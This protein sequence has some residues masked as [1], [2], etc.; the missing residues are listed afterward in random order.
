MAVEEEL[1]GL[2]AGAGGSRRE[3]GGALGVRRSGVPEPCVVGSF[4]AAAL[5][6]CFADWSTCDGEDV[7]AFCELLR[8]EAG[9][10]VTVADVSGPGAA[11]VEE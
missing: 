4:V 8:V 6:D 5:G 1:Q 10:S 9:L 11:V 2:D 7:G 3:L